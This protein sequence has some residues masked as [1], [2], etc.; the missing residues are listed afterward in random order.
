MCTC[1]FCNVTS[2]RITVTTKLCRRRKERDSNLQQAR[3]RHWGDIS[4]NCKGGMSELP[5]IQLILPFKISCICASSDIPLLSLRSVTTE[6]AE[7]QI[8][9]G[10]QESDIW[11]ATHHI[12]TTSQQKSAEQQNSDQN[13][14]D[15]KASR[16]Q[17]FNHKL[18]VRDSIIE[19]SS[20]AIVFSIFLRNLREIFMKLQE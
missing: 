1:Y 10:G 4:R 7:T 16:L 18:E 15:S 5:L 2:Q 14:S 6:S 13:M 11:L 19:L 20:F 3:W 9:E 12:I 17:S 8:S